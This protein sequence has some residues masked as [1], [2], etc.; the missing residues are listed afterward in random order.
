MKA[1]GV[2]APSPRPWRYLSSLSPSPVLGL[3]FEGRAGVGAG[4][5][6]QSHLRSSGFFTVL[7]V[8]DASC[9][10]LPLFAFS[11]LCKML[12][13]CSGC[14]L[15]RARPVVNAPQPPSPPASPNPLGSAVDAWTR[16][17]SNQPQT[18]AAGTAGLF[19]PTRPC[20]GVGW[21]EKCRGLVHL[22]TVTTHPAA[23][24]Y[25]TLIAAHSLSGCAKSNAS[26]V[27]LSALSYSSVYKGMPGSSGTRGLRGDEGG[28]CTNPSEG[29]SVNP[30]GNL[31]VKE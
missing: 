1:S 17:G 20:E 7:C 18:A 8:A 19:T 14:L 12:L 31:V 9:R 3:A 28:F 10:A 2:L 21:A 5:A 23:S 22:A 6:I 30:F 4:A 15:G 24:S 26:V 29:S 16:L 27:I 11:K 13:R 25:R